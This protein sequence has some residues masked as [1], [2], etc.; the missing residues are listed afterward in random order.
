MSSETINTICF[1]CHSRCGVLLEVKDGKL[2]G[3]RGD[4]EHPFSRGFIC[5][6]ARACME[7]VYHP[8]RI[9]KPLVR[10]GDKA[11]GRFEETTWDLALDIIAEKLLGYREKWGAESVVLG[12]G[13]TRGLPP[14]IGPF[15]SLFGSPNYMTPLNYSGGPI[16]VGSVATC[17]F[18]MADAD[19]KN[20]KC[21][22]LWAHN[23]AA[24]WAGL[25]MHNINQG[26][27]SGAKLIV[28]DPRG[29][30]LAKKSDHWLPIRPGTDVALALCFIRIIIENG[31]YDQEFVEKW[32]TGFDKLQEHVA[33]F[34]PERVADITWLAADDIKATALTLAK[35]SPTAFGLG[36]AGVCHA[37][38]AFDLVRSLTIISAITGN[39]EVPGGNMKCTAPTGRRSCY[40][41]EF[42]P[43]YNLP[44]EQAQKKLGLDTYPLSAKILMTSFSESIWP[45]ILEGKPYPVKAVGLFANNS[46]CAYGNSPQVKEALT[47]LDFLFSADYFHT[48]TT[49]LSDVI[50]PPAHWTER[51]D[52][53]DLLMKNHVFCQP[54]AVDPVPECW[55]EK[56][57]LIDLAK[58]MNLKGYYE[59]VT[60]LLDHRLEKTG[61]T[62]EAFKQVG[63]FSNP[64]E[65]RSYEKY[66]GFLTASKKVELYSDA[67]ESMGIEPMP[68]FREPGESPGNTPNLYEEFP[69][70]LTTGA[71]NIVYYHSAHRNI[72]SLRK[73]S[74]DPELQIHPQTAAELGI[75]DGE[76]VYLASP[77]G[78]VE[79]KARFFKHIH[80][81][82]VAAPHGYWYGV[83]DGW[84]RLNINML[85]DNKP[86]DPVTAGPPIK[87]LLCRVEKVDSA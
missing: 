78:R 23:P 10:V 31:L 61:L 52:V 18:S 11:G 39:L 36:M 37:N 44:E 81:K 34:T 66:N 16:I 2:T 47:R 53:E 59:S 49:A 9:T 1:E 43:L 70:V 29:T 21:I 4:K 82:V 48:P 74:P 83:E 14:S 19:Y 57:I 56:K 35:T 79:I 5:P 15:L 68:V 50:L 13:T 32:T 26:L 38:D 42:D 69:L 12:Q 62:F 65:Y 87:A 8:E 67:L 54:K 28:V 58:K 41:M 75:V 6:K 17:G 55:D 72:P 45:A 51:D 63:K 46:L 77:R 60:E 20:S 25:F 3:I 85:T 22:V 7:I 64:I 86:L 40:G 76:W 84:R 80:P 33:P 24:S 30:N 73:H 71:R 27:K